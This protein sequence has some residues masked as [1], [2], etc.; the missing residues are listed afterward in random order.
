M[1]FSRHSPFPLF[2]FFHTFVLQIYFRSRV[3]SGGKRRSQQGNGNRIKILI[4]LPF[5]RCNGKSQISNTY[6]KGVR[7]ARLLVRVLYRFKFD[8]EVRKR[9]SI[10]LIEGIKEPSVRMRSSHLRHGEADD[11]NISSRRKASIVAWRQRSHSFRS[12]SAS[13][14]LRSRT[15]INLNFL[16]M[17]PPP[18]ERRPAGSVWNNKMKWRNER[19]ASA[20]IIRRK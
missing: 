17:Q 16:S 12:I 19:D 5:H 1:H 15:Q 4:S 14:S 18:S 6:V 2:S 20:R 7:E 10:L 8:E 11:R 9:R 13:A 3:L